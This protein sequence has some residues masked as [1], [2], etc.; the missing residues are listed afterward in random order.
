M[1]VFAVGV[2][3]NS[4]LYLIAVFVAGILTAH[5]GAWRL[6][7][8]AF[9]ITYLS[10]LLGYNNALYRLR[11]IGVWQAIAAGLSIIVG[12]LAGLALLG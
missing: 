7:I 6:A 1:N 4:A 2:M 5:V 11:S 8:V 12:L 3:V 9:G 10:Y